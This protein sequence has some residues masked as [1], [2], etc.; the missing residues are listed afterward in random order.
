MKRNG[1]E[2]R[3][4]GYWDIRFGMLSIVNFAS[5]VNDDFF[6]RARTSILNFK[7]QRNKLA[8]KKTSNQ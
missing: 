1:A 7:H 5:Q 6:N 8:T 3:D 2:I 4:S